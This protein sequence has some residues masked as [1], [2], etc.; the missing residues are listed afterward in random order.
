MSGFQCRCQREL[1]LP[2]VDKFFAVMA[3]IFETCKPYHAQDFFYHLLP[4]CGDDDAIIQRLAALLE[5]F[6]EDKAV[7]APLLCALVL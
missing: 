4:S 6:P 2:Y 3:N 5:S 7:R 1:L